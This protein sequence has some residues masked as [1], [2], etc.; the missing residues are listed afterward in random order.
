MSKLADLIAQN[1]EITT[2]AV[3]DGQFG[4]T[5]KGKIVDELASGWARFVVRANGG[6]NAGHT[7]WV[8]GQKVVLH[9]IPVGILHMNVTN[10]IGTGVAFDP[11][12]FCA[13]L[14][15]LMDVDALASTPLVSHC[16]K[17]VLPQHILIDR[18]REAGADGTLGTTGRTTGR[19]IGPCY[20]DHVA[21]CGLTVNDLS[22]PDE[23]ARKLRA[24]LAEKMPFLREQDPEK[25]KAILGQEELGSGELFTPK[26]DFCFLDVDAIIAQYRQFENQIIVANTDEIVR[27]AREDGLRI[28]LEGAQGLMLDLNYGRYP[29]VTCSDC[30]VEGLAKG[31]G[32]RSEDVDLPL[33]IFKAPYMTC[34]GMGSFPTEIFG[35]VA[36]LIRGA[37]NEYGATTGR[38]RRVG[39]FDIPLARYALSRC[40]RAKPDVNHV[41]LT[42]LDVLTGFEPIKICFEYV[43]EGPDYSFAGRRIRTGERL[44]VAIP[45]EFVLSQCRPIYK[46]F[47]GW[48]SSPCLAQT[49]KDL[50][51]R[52]EEIINVIAH[53]SGFM[54][55]AASVGAERDQ[56]VILNELCL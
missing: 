12:A 9:L 15:Q 13:E 45:D 43:Y 46:Y 2:V 8:D 56:T 3:T 26:P 6:A 11:R 10:I 47:P 7:I 32:L 30:T 21:R 38:P 24:N 49:S 35:E 20:T 22:N 42:K 39:W 48:K 4:D 23:L 25:I 19:G 53:E 52:L 37:G 36:E 50:P 31:A 34:V 41:I 5:G 55:L 18:L 16:A 54:P 1:P 40:R 44:Q 33:T 29:Y 27:I 51:Y 14:H 28:L 17:L